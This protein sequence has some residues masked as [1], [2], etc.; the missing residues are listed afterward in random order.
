VSGTCTDQAGKTALATA[1]F[2]YDA[3]PPTVSVST[4]TGDHLVTLS[5]QAGGDVA[6]VVSLEITRSRAVGGGSKTMLHSGP[7]GTFTDTHVSDFV[8][9]RYTITAVDQAGNVSVRTVTAVPGP[10]LLWPPI[11]I[12]LTAPPLLL[13]TAV[14]GADYY[15]VQLYRSTQKVLSTW[16]GNARLQLKRSWSYR[17]RRFQLK[18]GRYNWYV[19]PGYGAR[20]AARYGRLIGR[21]TFV[22]VARR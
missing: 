6:P 3:T 2:A 18:P 12:Y 22:I 21:G 9:Y 8:R 10:R 14:R 15:N 5:W 19:W 7:T 13:W 17:G 1:S 4:K 11:G 16:P 20:S